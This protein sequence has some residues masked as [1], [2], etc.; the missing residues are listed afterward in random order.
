M[1]LPWD[2]PTDR[3]IAWLLDNGVSE[4]AMLEPTPLRAANVVF[5]GGNTFDFDS[6]GTRAFIFKEPN[7]LVAWNPKRDALAAWGC[8]AFALGEDAIWNPASYFMGDALRVHRTPLDWLKADRD[9]IVIVKPELTYGYLRNVR[10]LSF[11]DP[12]YAQQVKQWLQPPKPAVEIL[13]EILAER[14]VA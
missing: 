8:S 1:K 9:G 12:V 6:D 3:E 11:A 7:D 5:L 14:A 13:V 2:I 4:A 10:R